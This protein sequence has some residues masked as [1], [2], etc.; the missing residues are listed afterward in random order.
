MCMLNECL[1]VSV[2]ERQKAKESK[3]Q[4]QTGKSDHMCSVV[5]SQKNWFAKLT[6]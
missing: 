5:P 4:A 1:F 6:R 3:L 2:C